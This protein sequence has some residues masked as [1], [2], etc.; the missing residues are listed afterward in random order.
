MKGLSNVL[1]YSKGIIYSSLSDSQVC[2]VLFT[3]MMQ[4]NPSFDV[5]NNNS[6]ITCDFVERTDTGVWAYEPVPR[7]VGESL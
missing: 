1:D 6:F 7:P 2:S 4:P 5:I 3:L